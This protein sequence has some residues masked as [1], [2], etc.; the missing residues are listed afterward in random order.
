VAQLVF[1]L[2]ALYYSTVY[3]WCLDVGY[4]TRFPVNCP[5]VQVKK[6]NSCQKW[7]FL[8][9]NSDYDSLESKFIEKED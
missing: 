7:V 2:C 9:I 4:S 6:G 8:L 3:H 5:S 1:A